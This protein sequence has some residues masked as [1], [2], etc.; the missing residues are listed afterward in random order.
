MKKVTIFKYYSFGHD[1]K[2]LL[3]RT[4]E[5][6]NDVLLDD[7][8]VFL[9]TIEE[10][11][12]K[13][14]QSGI[15]QKELKK[16]K[17]KLEKLISEKKGAEKVPQSIISSIK[18]KLDKIDHI[19][20]AEIQLKD[21]YVLDEKRYSLTILTERIDKLFSSDSYNKIPTI[22]Q[23]DFK[24]AGMCLA[25][26]RFTASAFHLLR[27]TED[28]LRFFFETL[29]NKKSKITDTWGS[30]ST[31][32]NKEIKDKNLTPEPSKELMMNID[33]L[34]IFYRNKTQHPDKI[35]NQDEVQD[36]FGISI[37]TVNEII[38]DL[39]KRKLI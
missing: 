29:L 26:D 4:E 22:A 19:L 24:E 21:G 1:Y 28:I 5:T 35:Y 36:L 11:E 27:G 17:K 8:N 20:D 34:R 10:L 33:N 16:D 31:A 38:T 6:T 14:T 37:K 18:S 30:Y 25:F 23:Y 39:E 15:E 7:L 32:I 9:D 13:V 3:E 2:L 12:L